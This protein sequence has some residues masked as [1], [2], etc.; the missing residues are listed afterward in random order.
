MDP[1]LSSFDLHTHTVHSK[2]GM[3]LPRELFGLMR[4]RG[5]TGI[6]ITEHERP[7][8]TRVIHRDGMFLIPACEFKSTDYGELIGLFI[9]RPLP[10]RMS[11][12][13]TAETIA[14]QNGLRVLPHPCDRLRKHTAVRRHLPRGLIRKHVDL[15]EGINSRCIVPVFNSRAQELARTL[16]KPMTAGSDGHTTIEVG[17]A[18]TWL[19]GIESADDIY[20]A[21][22][23]GRT[24][25][26]GRCSPFFVHLPTAVWQR[27]RR[28]PL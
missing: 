5:L 16:G 13:E 18:R 12:V 17:T 26:S 2:D 6:A 4:R 24:R 20:E 1:G 9:D 19:E 25:I 11:F 28:W 23:H 8:L 27:T 14:E 22:A 21:L 15:V 10:H 3:L 7:S